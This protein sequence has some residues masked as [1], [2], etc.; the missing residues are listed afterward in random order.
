[1]WTFSGHNGRVFVASAS[2][3]ARVT[4]PPVLLGLRSKRASAFHLSIR[5]SRQI[6]VYRR[7]RMR[8]RHPRQSTQQSIKEGERAIGAEQMPP[9]THCPFGCHRR[10]GIKSTDERRRRDGRRPKSILGFCPAEFICLGHLTLSDFPLPP[11]LR[12]P[13]VCPGPVR[14]SADR[15]VSPGGGHR[16]VAT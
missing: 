7:G 10:V 6:P 2:D 15:A 16:R 12:R 8:W 4:F 14:L 1:M 9:P 11:S 5:H 13:P 3:I